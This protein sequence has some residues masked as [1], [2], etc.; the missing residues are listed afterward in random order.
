MRNVMDGLGDGAQPETGV[1]YCDD[2]PVVATSMMALRCAL[3][4]KL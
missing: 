1:I 4:D 3:L 2:L